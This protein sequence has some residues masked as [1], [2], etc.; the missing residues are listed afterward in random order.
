MSHNKQPIARIRVINECLSGGGFWSKKQLINEISKIDLDI[1]DRTLDND[2]NLMRNCAQLKYIAPIKYCKTNKGYY[3]TDHNYS[4]DKLPLNQTDIK[5]LELAATTLKQ[6]Q[7]IPIMKE[8]T[9]T[10]DKIIRVVNRAKQSNHESILDFIEFEKTPVAQGLEFID[11]IINA[12]QKKVALNI[13]YQK[14]GHEVSNSQIIHPYS[15]KEYRNRWYIVAF[16]E[17]KGDI[18]TYGLDR[19]KLL[20]EIDAPY[21]NN[22]F[23]DTKEY[24]SNCIGINLMDKKIDAVQLH[25]TSKEG[26]YIKTQPLHRSQV[27]LEDSS[28]SGLI[29]EYKLIINYELIGIIL[30]YGSHVKVIKPKFLADKIAE[31]SKRTRE[32]YLLH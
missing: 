4:I 9:A 22:K 16:N 32:Q 13:S 5:A 3:Y 12:I 14:F 18:R 26:N 23:I 20:I 27:I 19:I 29:L 24:L 15:L 21:I 30:S 10:I 7:Y 11:I 31:I 28:D 2:I 1:S 25:F 17:T 8:F 6:Y